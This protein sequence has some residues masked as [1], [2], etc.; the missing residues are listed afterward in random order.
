MSDNAKAIIVGSLIMA[1]TSVVCTVMITA[2]FHNLQKSAFGFVETQKHIVKNYIE[3]Q[4]SEAKRIALTRKERIKSLIR[5][6]LKN[7]N[8]DIK[9][10]PAI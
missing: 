9:T 5:Q 4:K 10:Q 6:E 1:I 2:S 7:T 3:A 8:I